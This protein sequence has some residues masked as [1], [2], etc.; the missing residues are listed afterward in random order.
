MAKSARRRLGLGLGRRA[1]CRALDFLLGSGLRL[2]ARNYRCR[3]GELDLLMLDGDC[4]VIIEV[5]YRS[6][7]R[8]GNATESVDARKQ[9]RMA[10]AAESFLARRREFADCPVRFDVVALDGAPGDNPS[11]EWLRDAFRL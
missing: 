10:M 9:A 8:F 4:L 11:L 5:R 2:V 1:E 7:S 3:F 6:A